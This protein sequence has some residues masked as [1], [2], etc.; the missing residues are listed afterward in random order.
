[1]TT[2]R[3]ID[4]IVGIKVLYECPTCNGV[5]NTDKGRC[6]L[7]GGAGVIERWMGIRDLAKT[8]FDMT[9][10]EIGIQ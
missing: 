7:C 2:T 9:P 6:V 1:M 8:I 10:K 4:K 3:D 5:L